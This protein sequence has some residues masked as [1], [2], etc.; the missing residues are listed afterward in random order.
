MDTNDLARELAVSRR[1][2]ERWER[3]GRVVPTSH[4]PSGRRRY[5]VEY[6]ES[7]KTCPGKPARSPGSTNAATNTTPAGTTEGLP[8]P[9]DF[10]FARQMRARRAVVSP[11]GSSSAKTS[12]PATSVSSLQTGRAHV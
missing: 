3:D 12:T 7:L 5:S 1:T 9:D 4:T 8:G 11:R 10:R 6:V 2:V